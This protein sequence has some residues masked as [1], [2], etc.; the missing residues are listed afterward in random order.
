MTTALLN[1]LVLISGM[2]PLGFGIRFILAPKKIVQKATEVVKSRRT[3][4]LSLVL[5]GV[6][7]VVSTLQP[8]LVSKTFFVVHVATHL[9]LPQLFPSDIPQ[10]VQTVWI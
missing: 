3:A 2:I 4:G 5:F 9:F 1:S 7:L 10:I 8:V 6:I